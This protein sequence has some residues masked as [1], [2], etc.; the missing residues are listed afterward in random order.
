MVLS[1]EQRSLVAAIQDGFD[2]VSHPYR[3]IGARLNLSEAETIRRIEALIGAGA[4]KR[5]GVV[6]RH[7]ELGYRANAMVV[8]N[9][10][11]D[12]VDAVG[13][14]LGSQREVSLCYRRPRRLPAWPY[15]LF[16][17]IHGHDQATVRAQ[18]HALRQSSALIDLPYATLFSTRRFK[19]RGAQYAFG[20][21][22]RGS[23]ECGDA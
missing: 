22:N 11:D 9:V 13:A 17:M 4:I 14:W 3:A 15:N 2:L 7:R 5:M 19:Q 16:C 21:G 8:F 1:E 20:A 12:R 6:V 23:Q 18:I 10:P